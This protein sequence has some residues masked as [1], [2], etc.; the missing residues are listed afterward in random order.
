MP[1]AAKNPVVKPDLFKTPKYLNSGILMKQSGFS[2]IELLIALAIIAI[3]ASVAVP[4]YSK[5]IAK[6]RVQQAQADLELL[7]VV[8][9]SQYQRVLFYPA[10]NY[11]TTAELKTAFP[12]WIPSSNTNFLNFANINASTETFTLT[13]NGIKGLVDNC[14][15]T[16]T[17][18]GTKTVS[19]CPDLAPDGTWL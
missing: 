11:A 6:G 14:V 10:T 3:L 17:Q 18:N 13:A 19:N 2:L 7:S 12:K 8:L 15:I 4:S 9:E 5:H 1:F 16:L